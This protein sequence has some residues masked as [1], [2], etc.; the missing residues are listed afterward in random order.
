MIGLR[1]TGF[2]SDNSV[3]FEYKSNG[4]RHNEISIGIF[5]TGPVP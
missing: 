3:F 2:Q 4:A 1:G 5:E